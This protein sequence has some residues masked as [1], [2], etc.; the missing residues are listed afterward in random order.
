MTHDSQKYNCRSIRLRD[1][2]YTSPGTYFITICT[3][4]RKPVF[5]EIVNNEMQLNELGESLQL[6]WNALPERFS[7]LELDHFVIMPDHIHGIIIIKETDFVFGEDS[8]KSELPERFRNSR[9]SKR[10]TNPV[11]ASFAPPNPGGAIN[12][13]PTVL[14][15]LRSADE[16]RILP[17]GEVIRTFKAVTT[18]KI[19]SQGRLD[20]KWQRNYHEHIIRKDDDLDRVRQYI[21]DN[22]AQWAEDSLN[23]EEILSWLLD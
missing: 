9:Y 20:F 17:L 6:I 11:S 4:D 22:P 19:R 10:A 23:K 8:Y 13:A 15:S 2:D 3:Q 14:P 5:G 12:L 16:N 1:Y 18:H 21:I 7:N